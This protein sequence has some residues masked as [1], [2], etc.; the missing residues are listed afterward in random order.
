M[1]TLPLKVA[2]VIMG[3]LMKGRFKAI[4]QLGKFLGRDTNSLIK[5]ATKYTRNAANKGKNSKPITG[6]YVREAT[7]KSFPKKKKVWKEWEDDIEMSYNKDNPLKESFMQKELMPNKG[8][9]RQVFNEPVPTKR[10]RVDKRALQEANMTYDDMMADYKKRRS[11]MLQEVSAENE[12]E[13]LIQKQRMSKK[14]KS[15]KILEQL[16]KLARN[17]PFEA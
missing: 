7:E 8:L 5:E 3:H 17:K 12:I 14:K 1:I 13:S 11:R 16:E 4:K 9:M 15:E 2:R 6:R 10:P